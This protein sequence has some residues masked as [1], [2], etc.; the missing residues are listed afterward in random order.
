MELFIPIIL[1]VFGIY[2]GW[3]SHIR[4]IEIKTQRFLEQ[5]KELPE[6]DNDIVKI[7]IEKERETL[8]VYERST[9]KFITQATN[10]TDLETKLAEIYPGKRFGVTPE[11]LEEIGFTS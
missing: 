9:N 2:L 1:F 7:I 8:Y 10:R 4:F 6:E 11:N 5:L 3:N